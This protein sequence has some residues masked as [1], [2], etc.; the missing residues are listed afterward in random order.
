MKSLK[1]DIIQR[2]KSLFKKDFIH[3]R[4]VTKA[5]FLY[6]YTIFGSIV[7]LVYFVLSIFW[8]WP[9]FL[10]LSPVYLIILFIVFVFLR[11]NL[12]VIW[13]YVINVE[14]GKMLMFLNRATHWED[15]HKIKVANWIYPGR[16]KIRKEVHDILTK[17]VMDKEELTAIEKKMFGFTPVFCPQQI[18]DGFNQALLVH[19]LIY[20]HQNIQPLDEEL[21]EVMNLT[22][23]NILK[24][25]IMAERKKAGGNEFDKFMEIGKRRAEELNK[26]K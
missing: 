20:G 4:K 14:R 9:K 24:F 25:D 21:R 11:K 13:F 6:L 1:L 15:E 2:L 23:D 10:A 12:K 19:V 8:G 16:K 5:R 18:K 26:S 22:D 7:G 17:K 3:N